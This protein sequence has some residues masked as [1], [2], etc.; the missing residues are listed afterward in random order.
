MSK[1]ESDAL[2]R[3]FLSVYTDAVSFSRFTFS[4]DKLDRVAFSD[5]I[6]ASEELAAKELSRSLSDK[7]K[8]SELSD[9]L[10]HLD[11]ARTYL[12]ANVSTGH[13]AGML[14]A[15]LVH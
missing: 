5:F 3:E 14:F 11:T 7:K 1:D 8:A 15:E 13:I 6:S 10:R 2:A 4:L 9:I 12:D